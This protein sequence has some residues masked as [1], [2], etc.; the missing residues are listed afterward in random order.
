M[1]VALLSRGT[2]TQKPAPL[3][4]L[5]G[6]LQLWDTFPNFPFPFQQL[7]S[8]FAHVVRGAEGLC[9]NPNP[10]LAR[11]RDGGSLHLQRGKENSRLQQTRCQQGKQ[12]GHEDKSPGGAPQAR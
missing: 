7:P 5:V 10:S 3:L 11:C 6:T 1:S 9:V 2:N 4:P 12:D 8:P